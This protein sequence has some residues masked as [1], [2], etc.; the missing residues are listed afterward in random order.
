MQQEDQYIS[1][2]VSGEEK[3]LINGHKMLQILGEQQW[4][5]KIFGNPLFLTYK[6]KKA[7]QNIK[8]LEHGMILIR[9]K[10]GGMSHD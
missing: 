8:N 6:G 4:I 5:L 9:Y 1:Q 10:F 7:Y 3:N 2:C